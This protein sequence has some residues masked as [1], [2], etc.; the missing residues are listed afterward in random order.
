MRFVF[1]RSTTGG[2]FLLLV[3]AG[4]SGCTLAPRYQRPASPVAE[5]WPDSAQ[6]QPGDGA[7]IPAADLAWQDFFGDEMLRE[8]VR[9]ALENN[10]DLRIAML[11]VEQAAAVYGIQRYALI[12]T[13]DATGSV[14]RQRTPAE[15]SP[16]GT[17]T[18]TSVYRVGLASTGYEL[19]LFGRIRSLR[20]QALAEYF[21]TDEA[22]KSA[23]ISLISAVATQYLALLSLDEQ[24]EL[25]RQ[26]YAA[27]EASHVITQRG[28]EIGS[29]SELDFRTSEAQ[30]QAA[31]AN[32][33]AAAR[34][35]TEAENALAVLVGQALP[36]GFERSSGL[37]QQRLV[38]D[39]TA[40]LPSDLLQRR[41]DIRSA[42]QRLKAANANIGVARAAFFPAIK[43]TGFGGTASTELDGL[44]ESGSTTW[45]FVPDLTLPIFDAGVN[46]ATLDIA[47]L[48]KQV[49]I[50]NYERTI[51]TAFQE[52][53]DALAA[54]STLEEQL[55][56]QTARVAAEQRRYELSELRYRRGVDNYVTVLLAQQNLFA[57]QQ[58]LIQIRFAR[59][60]NQIALYKALGGGWKDE[61]AESGAAAAATSGDSPSNP[62]RDTLLG[63]SEPS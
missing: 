45:S 6:V 10:R 39:L 15:L 41:P 61:A 35:R 59:L 52:V 57:A 26:T 3:A 48:G 29:V 21:A 17:A 1:F 56:A 9:L 8:V 19:D 12:P 31:R 60:A 47:K 5:Q 44:F 54:R 58:G 27:V 22:R 25:A 34:Q 42:E 46:R 51:Q 40:G 11:N 20:D 33:A 62:S 13:V 49:E 4:L 43:L 23:H 7:R 32:I 50:A 30:L 2:R 38:A 24:L 55:S 63:V 14:T 28:Y 53:A 36:A 18:T 16:S 37:E